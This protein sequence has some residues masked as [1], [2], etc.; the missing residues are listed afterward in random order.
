MTSVIILAAVFLL[1]AVR[2]IGHIHFRI[3]QVMLAGA[4]AVLLTGQI[5]PCTALKSI[6][7]D[8]I[9]FLFGMF[10]IGQALE[11]SGYLAH[12]SQHF[13]RL[14]ASTNALVLLVIFGSGLLAAVLMN[15]TLAIV[16]TP[17]LL[18]LAQKSKINA[19]PLLLALAFGITTGSVL[20]PIG[21]PQNLLIALGGNITNPFLTFFRYLSLPTLV[22]M[23]VVYVMLKI[24]YPR[25]FKTAVLNSNE[26]RIMNARLARLCQISL[27]LLGVLIGM[28]IIMVF[29]MP[30]FDFRLTYI[31]LIS[32]LPILLFSRR[33]F[34][35]IKRLDWSTL[36]FFASMFILMASVWGSGIFQSVMERLHLDLSNQGIVLGIS[37]IL[38]QFISNVP[39]VAL[40]L[41]VLS[42]SGSSTG[43]FMALA[44]GSTIAGNLTILG[45]ASNVIIIQSCENK[46]NES[47]TFWEFFRI[48]LPLTV[49]QVLI[50]WLFLYITI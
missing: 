30:Q 20:S 18:I 41:P 2:N 25:F 13:F 12:I 4:I 9:I 3:W 29:I 50:Y 36:I 8:V 16:G 22:N 7:F 21:N 37:I 15:D 39:M 28:K 49:V 23:L 44:A 31:S 47:I 42:Q 43:I 5:T 27:V 40:Y 1:I 34:E 48:G 32:A 38:S 17:L 10:V 35:R 14:G 11:E 24:Y 6:D 45:A 33:R 46:S 19:K 26:E